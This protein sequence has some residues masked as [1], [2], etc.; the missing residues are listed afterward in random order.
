MPHHN[1]AHISGPFI[2]AGHVTALPTNSFL[3]GIR[4]PMLT[5]LKI[6]AHLLWVFNESDDE[7]EVDQWTLY[8]CTAL[9]RHFSYFKA[10]GMH[11]HTSNVTATNTITLYDLYNAF[12][13]AFCR[14]C[15]LLLQDTTAQVDISIGLHEQ[16][17][18]IELERSLTHETFN[19]FPA[20]FVQ[21][22]ATNAKLLETLT[23]T[24]NPNRICQASDP[25]CL[26][27]MVQTRLEREWI[28]LGDAEDILD[29]NSEFYR[30]WQELK[31]AKRELEVRFWEVWEG[32]GG[33]YDVAAADGFRVWIDRWER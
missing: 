12:T 8:L 15:T 28:P 1:P 31:G 32:V 16:E 5:R 33:R 29:G 22:M 26:L 13:E 30:R 20:L 21:T 27:E 23:Q 25:E 6:P 2:D 3:K 9:A 24:S 19:R 11:Y 10:Y 4:D 18:L 7:K 14:A 17:K